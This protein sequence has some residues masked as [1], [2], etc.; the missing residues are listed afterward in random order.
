[1][2]RSITTIIYTAVIL[3]VMGCVEKQNTNLRCMRRRSREEMKLT[4]EV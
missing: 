1:M 2:N 3:P 4:R